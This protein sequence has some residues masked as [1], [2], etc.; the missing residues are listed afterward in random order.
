MYPLRYISWSQNRPP[1]P[2]GGPLF[3]RF[4]PEFYLKWGVYYLVA[5]IATGGGWY[6]IWGV[7]YLGGLPV[8]VQGPELPAYELHPCHPDFVLKSGPNKT[9]V[10]LEITKHARN[11]RFSDFFSLQGP[12]DFHWW[13]WFEANCIFLCIAQTQSLSLF[14]FFEP[15]FLDFLGFQTAPYLMQIH[16]AHDSALLLSL[17]MFHS[18]GQLGFCLAISRFL[19]GFKELAVS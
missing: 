7:L 17:F 9:P 18:P 16:R 12:W 6:F 14:S 4:F 2:V 10:V 8:T 5:K 15:I 1:P 11:C 13:R 19:N 3:G